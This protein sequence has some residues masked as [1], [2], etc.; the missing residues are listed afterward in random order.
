MKPVSATPS[1]LLVSV[2]L[3]CVA[4]AFGLLVAATSVNSLSLR[5][6]P[7]DADAVIVTY[8][9][10]GAVF[11]DPGP[12]WG[13]V[14]KAIGIAPPLEGRP[15]D[16][17]A[18]I[19]VTS[20][21]LVPEPDSLASYAE[22]DAFL[23]RQTA[24]AEVMA[25]DAVELYLQ[26][27]FTREE[28]TSVLYTDVREVG[29]LADG[30]WLQLVT[31]VA[32]LL[33][34]GWVWALRP[35]QLGPIMFMLSAIGLNLSTATSALYA[36][37]ELALHADVYNL[38]V[39][40]NHLGVVVFGL[41]M[42][43]LLLSYPR[44]LVRPRWL[45]LL[46]VS[47]A[48][49]TVFDLSH[50]ELGL[51][52]SQLY[53]FIALAMLGIL[54]AIALQWR[55][56]RGSP[57]DRAALGW[58][59]LSVVAGAGAYTLLGAAPILLDSPFSLPQSHVTSV[60]VIIYAGLAL[61]LSRYRLFDL[62]EWSYRILF[63]TIGALVLLALDAAII[64][65]L[66]IDAAPA[67]GISLLLVAFVYLPA[68]D[69]VWRR[70][71]TRR[72]V[73]QDELFSAALD[74]AFAPSPAESAARWRALLR[75]LFDPLQIDETAAAG[76]LPE[77]GD[78]GLSMYLPA[79]A[80]APPLRMTYPFA[81]RGLFSPTHLK[82][83]T[84]LV[85]LTVRAEEGRAAYMR[86]VGEERRRMARDLHDDVGA[87]LLTGLHTADE[88]TRPTLQA[89]LSDIR[90]IVSGLAGDEASLDR[91]LA[92]TRHEA[93]RRL[94]AAEIALDWP[95][96]EAEIEDIQLDYRLHKALTSAV[97]EIVSNVIRHSGASKLTVTPLLAPGHLSL[98]FVD[99]GKGIPAE[100]LA[101]EAAGFGLRNLRH[102]I[103]DI[104]GR[105]TLSA[106][107]GRTE[108]TLDIPLVLSSHT[109]EPGV[110]EPALPLN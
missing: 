26:D 50:V 74:V 92:E 55:A 18:P 15:T 97:R 46:L 22:Y 32:S 88:A 106:A 104:G 21:D 1:L 45:W 48:A 66:N 44:Q 91:V 80:S 77:M 13:T 61:G 89:A 9:H 107:P 36:N 90:A 31:G 27:I 105:L 38:L 20:A 87:R 62:G 108:I 72:T 30:F 68:R 85:S 94:E 65:L 103:E 10:D 51:G 25:A 35:R 109:P 11:S 95:L 75:Q 96:P 8:V 57:H 12:R 86:G 33:I 64:Y 34:A 2:T 41:A 110:P 84:N 6:A 69:L 28:F 71:T 7:T 37:R 101:G 67:L 93:A 47:G 73:A 81:G 79:V 100:A 43:A 98:R 4:L 19:P 53:V 40:I 70:V 23:A 14:L 29:T 39:P 49:Y 78:D 17:P 60:L 42:I 76:A 82:L 54:T 52:P 16:W 5:L 58:L 99:D 63:Y 102:R 83:A 59:G 56:T 3:V 24:L